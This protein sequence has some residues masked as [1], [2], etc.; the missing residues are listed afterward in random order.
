VDKKETEGRIKAFLR[1]YPRGL[2]ITRMASLLKVNRNLLAKH[3]EVLEATGQVT[4][5]R[6]GP[7]RVF[8]L[9]HRV[10]ASALLGLS[11]DMVCI[12][13]GQDHVSFIND[14]FLG[15]LGLPRE[16]AMGCGFPELFERVPVL[17]L[18]GSF[19][20]LFT[21]KETA[22]ETRLGKNGV[23][24]HLKVKGIPTL[25][26]DGTTG[27]TLLMEDVT[28]EREY[29][30]ELEFLAKTSAALAEMRDDEDI[31][32]FIV[33]HIRDL[34]PQ[35]IVVISSFGPE[36]KTLTMR[37]VSADEK[38][39]AEFSRRMGRDLEGIS[40]PAW[41]DRTALEAFSRKELVEAPTLFHLFFGQVPDTITGCLERD[42]SLGKG[43]AIGCVCR[44]GI[45]GSI[46]IKLKK[47]VELR[48]R[49]TLMAFINQAA[50][51][52]QRRHL[53]Q[54]YQLERKGR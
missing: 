25:F 29:V 36:E 43:Y 2:T 11:K 13:D 10:P 35:S 23:E 45:Y 8:Y 52:L 7:T 49:E 21:G 19:P 44:G 46:L 48:H 32:R 26:E 47:G 30:Q 18:A 50:I 1:S 6:I 41:K 5:E 31:Y 39:L 53:K 12:F 24:F 22:G 28:K 33:D 54:K 16:A 20:D 38:D 40:F 51:A 17:S 34:E 42:L 37:A 9:A 14:S 4:S 3:L 15:F 27:T